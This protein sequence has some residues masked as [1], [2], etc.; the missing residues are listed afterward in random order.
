MCTV[1]DL[2]DQVLSLDAARPRCAT[3]VNRVSLLGTASEAVGEHGALVDDEAG[4]AATV[5]VVAYLEQ[6]GAV[7]GV[8]YMEFSEAVHRSLREQRTV[9][10]PFQ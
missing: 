8:R 7:D 6:G 9:A 3:V 1:R 10:V 2:P 4:A 5:A